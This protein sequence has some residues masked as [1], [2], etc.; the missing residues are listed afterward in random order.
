M[1]YYEIHWYIMIYYDIYWYIMIYYDILLYYDSTWLYYYENRAIL[2]LLRIFTVLATIW[3]WNRAGLVEDCDVILY[4]LSRLCDGNDKLQ[5]F[6]RI[7]CQWP[8]WLK[9]GHK[10]AMARTVEDIAVLKSELGVSS[11]FCLS[12]RNPVIISCFLSTF[13]TY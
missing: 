1:Y 6:T 8:M 4:R 9:A 11:I 3:A 12:T 7:H 5:L 13:E 2:L 10:R